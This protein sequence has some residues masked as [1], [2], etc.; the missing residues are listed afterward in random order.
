MPAR[1]CAAVSTARDAITVPEQDPV[2]TPSGP[3]ILTSTTGDAA[4][5][6]FT[7]LTMA[8]PIA[9]QELL[10]GTEGVGDGEGDVGLLLPPPHAAQT[11]TATNAIART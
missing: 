7:P 6:Q 3:R 1:Q 2:G 9:L 5:E 10:T 4:V 8:M 11:T